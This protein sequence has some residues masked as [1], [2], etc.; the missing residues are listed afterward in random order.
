MIHFY[1]AKFEQLNAVP[2]LFVKV[3]N[4]TVCRDKLRLVTY[5]TGEISVV[6]N[7]QSCKEG[8]HLFSLSPQWKV[9]QLFLSPQCGSM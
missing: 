9:L 5:D 3:R 1:Y 8:L 2:K 7:L 4:I 6:W